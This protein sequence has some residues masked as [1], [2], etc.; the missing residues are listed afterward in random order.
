MNEKISSHNYPISDKWMI[1]AIFN[2]IFVSI[3]FTFLLGII[4]YRPLIALITS[5]TDSYGDSGSIW[6]AVGV[7]FIAIF[8]ISVI[9]LAIWKKNFYFELTPD[10]VLRKTSVLGTQE[11]HLPYK[12]I[13]DIILRQSFVEKLF[14]LGTIVIQNAAYSMGGR[15][16]RGMRSAGVTIVGQPYDKAE[17][18]KDILNEIVK[19]QANPQSMGM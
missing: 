15:G 7:L 18:L 1:V 6:L 4:L 17:K 13:Q 16:A 9:R 11:T 2:S 3:Y 12:S 10:Y 14:G 8:I 19:N 5:Y